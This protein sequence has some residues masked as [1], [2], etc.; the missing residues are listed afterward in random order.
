[1]PR[2]PKAKLADLPTILAELL[3]QFGNSPVNVE[4]VAQINKAAGRR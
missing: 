2:N 3:E 4:E 1:M